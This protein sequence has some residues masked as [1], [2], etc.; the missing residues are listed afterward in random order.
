MLLSEAAAIIGFL[1]I[2]DADNVQMGRQP[3]SGTPKYDPLSKTYFVKDLQEILDT[4]QVVKHIRKKYL[5]INS[6]R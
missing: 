4:I 3:C 5:R 1:E 2:V 6:S